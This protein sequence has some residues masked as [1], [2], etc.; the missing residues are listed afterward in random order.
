MSQ[1][2]SKN[3]KREGGNSFAAYIGRQVRS[4]RGEAA[5]DQRELARQYH[6]GGQTVVTR[7]ERANF[8]SLT[9]NQ[10]EGLIRFAEDCGKSA[11]W[12]FTGED[13]P[14]PAQPAATT[15]EIPAMAEGGTISIRITP[16]E[17]SA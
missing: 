14:E 1:E 7:I 8:Q 16:V 6:L 9:A 2:K 10:L 15:L 11:Q 17:K 3:I 4:L 13:I 5:I 12:L